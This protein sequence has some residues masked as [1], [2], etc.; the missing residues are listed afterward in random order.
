L[1]SF[2]GSM[3]DWEY[4]LPKAGS[5]FYPNRLAVMILPDETGAVHR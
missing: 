2:E 4:P 5:L 3:G 1:G